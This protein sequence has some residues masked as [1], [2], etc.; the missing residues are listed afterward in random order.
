VSLVVFRWVCRGEDETWRGKWLDLA[1][2]QYRSERITG[3]H[4][5]A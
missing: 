3:P 1:A 4:I 5:L 2:K